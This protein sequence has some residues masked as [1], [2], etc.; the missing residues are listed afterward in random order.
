MAVSAEQRIPT[1]RASDLDTGGGG[2]ATC[3]EAIAASVL[4]LIGSVSGILGT[5]FVC[6]A[7]QSRITLSHYLTL[8]T[9]RDARPPTLPDRD[10]GKTLGET[11]L[12]AFIFFPLFTKNRQTGK[13]KPQA[14]ASTLKQYLPPQYR[15]HG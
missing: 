5:V 10:Q 3:R 12:P 13:S 2:I 7:Q 14:T 1:N 4:E 9:N 6:C 8:T 11:A 15:H